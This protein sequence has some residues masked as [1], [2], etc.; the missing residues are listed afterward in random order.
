MA[1]IVL[2]VGKPM[3]GQ[4]EPRDGQT[5]GW[6]RWKHNAGFAVRRLLGIEMD[7]EI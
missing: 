5:V 1:S 4:D 2:T 6:T 7:S 3:L